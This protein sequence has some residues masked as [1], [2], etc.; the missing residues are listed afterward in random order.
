MDYLS[1]TCMFYSVPVTSDI[2]KLS[3]IFFLSTDSFRVKPDS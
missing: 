3:E 1:D 2:L